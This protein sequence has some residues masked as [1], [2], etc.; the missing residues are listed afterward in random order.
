VLHIYVDEQALSTVIHVPLST[1]PHPT[2][3]TLGGRTLSTLSLTQA[4]TVPT[5]GIGH[6]AAEPGH[7]QLTF[8]NAA[9]QV[10]TIPAGTLLIGKDGVEVVTDADA[11]IVAAVFPTEGQVA[12]PAH[13]VNVG[14]AGNIAAQEIYGACCREN[15]FVQNTAAFSGGQDART[16]PMVTAQD[17]VKAESGLRT[18]LMQSVGAAFKAELAAA[19]A[20]ILP[21]PCREHVESSREIGQEATAV[22]IQLSET[23]GDMAYDTQALNTLVTQQLARQTRYQLGT[24]YALVG[25][26]TTTILTAKA[27]A[28][29]FLFTVKGTGTW[30]YQFTLAELQHLAQ[31]IAGK[32]AREATVILLQQPGVSQVELGTTVTLPANAGRIHVLVIEQGM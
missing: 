30:A 7:G 15:V 9:P 17:V 18:S 5:T 31:Q 23:C 22:T 12:I 13:A 25:S 3:G 26:V 28:G 6:Q 32:S 24:S 16:F 8:Y 29:T 20:F 4:R 14:P 2:P 27:E 19:E 21:I 11:I 1:S 10:Q